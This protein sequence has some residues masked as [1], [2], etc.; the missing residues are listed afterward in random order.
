MSQKINS[1]S[2]TNVEHACNSQA[3]FFYHAHMKYT[4]IIGITLFG[5]LLA[6]GC[7]NNKANPEP[8]HD[9]HAQEPISTLHMLF[10]LDENLYSG[11]EPKGRKAY[12]QLSSLGIQTVISV[13][14]V[15]PDKALA[16]EFG[17]RV[18]HLPI[19]YDGIS[20]ERSIQFAH[21]IATL[22]SPIYIHCHHGKH[23]GPAAIA[24]GAIGAGTMT[25]MQA[26]Q[27]MTLVGTS[28]DYPGLWRAV[29][30]ARP[31]NDT[32]LLNDQIDLPE[33]ADIGDFLAA[34]S[35]ID[36][37][38]E[39]LWLCA[40]NSFTAPN[41]HPDLAPASLAGHIHNLLRQLE[42]DKLTVQ[43]GVIFAELMIE[44]RDLASSLE[45]QITMND[46]ENAM[47]SMTTL[48][49]SCIRCHER[50]RD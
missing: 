25:H 3:C 44:S 49:E 30:N 50:F 47:I 12:E 48:S 36:R 4:A 7:T 9:A 6:W 37:L 8:E 2:I 22:P 1:E 15:A 11:G 46:I 5:S 18:V 33:Q 28:L 24:V 34:M 16:D 23:R 10:Q 31:L 40:E 35:E 19:G 14:A 41:D 45:T 32:Y 21:A 39:L 29:Q 43:E 27:F 17:I 38:D 26:H 13:D 42:T 20:S